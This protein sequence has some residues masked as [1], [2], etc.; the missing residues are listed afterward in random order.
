MAWLVPD[1]GGF[2]RVQRIGILP[3]NLSLLEFD[4]AWKPQAGGDWSTR[5]QVALL[6]PDDPLSG[7]ILLTRLPARV[8]A[9]RR[10]PLVG[11][12]ARLAFLIIK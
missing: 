7:R 12:L 11:P 1:G 10:G 3:V 6:F 9:P 5:L 4:N 2:G 8:D